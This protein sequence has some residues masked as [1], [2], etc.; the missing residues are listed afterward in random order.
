LPPAFNGAVIALFLCLSPKVRL[1]DRVAVDTRSAYVMDVEVSGVSFKL[2][3]EHG[4]YSGP[5]FKLKKSGSYGLSDIRHH[6]AVD[7]ELAPLC[8]MTDSRTACSGVN[9][10]CRWNADAHK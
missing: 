6:P 10:Y 5:A 9:W 8:G 1:G 2:L 4:R 3:D 7:D